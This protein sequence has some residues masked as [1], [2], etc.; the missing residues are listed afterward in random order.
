[1][2]E[3]VLIK[4][5]DKKVI[6]EAIFASLW[7]TIDNENYGM[8]SGNR[9]RHPTN[10][11]VNLL[12]GLGIWIR[13]NDSVVLMGDNI[14]FKIHKRYANRKVNGMYKTLKPTLEYIPQ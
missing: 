6:E 9:H 8:M 7:P 2:K 1:M 3:K 10:R 12:W 11:E 5:Y 13:W 4:G 14:L